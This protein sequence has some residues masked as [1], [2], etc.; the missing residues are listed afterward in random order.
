MKLDRQVYLLAVLEGWWQK[1]EL[2]GH[3]G[4]TGHLALLSLV[5]SSIKRVRSFELLIT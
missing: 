5:L 1:T 2:I 3:S 4:L